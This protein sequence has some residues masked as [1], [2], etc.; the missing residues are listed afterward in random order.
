MGGG[1]ETDR[2]GEGQV[3]RGE[4]GRYLTEI[5]KTDANFEHAR[6]VELK[7]VHRRHSV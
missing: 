3:E 5:C 1:K 7:T 2:P 6:Y 4:G